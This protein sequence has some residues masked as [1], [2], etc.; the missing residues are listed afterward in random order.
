MHEIVLAQNLLA[1]ILEEAKN[2]NRKPVAA[3]ISCGALSAVNDEALCF[4]FDA[5]AK[6]TACEG[7]KLQVEHKSLQARCRNCGETFGVES[8]APK[9][10]NCGGEDFELLDDAPLLLEQIEFGEK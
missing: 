8:A 1:A 7:L 9:C 4:A 2:H 3:K 5:L 6:D 10:S